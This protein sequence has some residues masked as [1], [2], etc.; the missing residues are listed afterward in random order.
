MGVESRSLNV[1]H[2]FHSPLMD[3]ILDPFEEAAAGLNYNARKIDLISNSDW[4]GG[5][6]SG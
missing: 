3:P 6:G 1:S 5:K 2:A 4:R